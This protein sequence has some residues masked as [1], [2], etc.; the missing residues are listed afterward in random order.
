M[1]QF[2]LA[3]WTSNSVSRL[4]VSVFSIIESRP[5]RFRLPVCHKSFVPDECSAFR[6]LADYAI[7]EGFRRGSR[8][9]SSERILLTACFNPGR[10]RSTTAHVASSSIPKY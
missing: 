10:S 3:A 9:Y 8:H 7:M 4:I 5:C 6:P 2:G 1:V